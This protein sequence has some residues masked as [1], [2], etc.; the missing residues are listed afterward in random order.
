VELEFYLGPVNAVM[1]NA[2]KR[3]E[4]G[5]I[6]SDISIIEKADGFDPGEFDVAIVGVEEGI[7]SPGNEECSKAPDEIR[8]QLYELRAFNNGLRVAD[9][10]NIR[11]RT[12]NDKLIALTEVCSFLI[13]N[14]VIPVVIGGG[15]DFTLAI[16]GAAVTDGS[17]NLT[18]LDHTI[19][20]SEDDGDLTSGSFLSKLFSEKAKKPGHIS[21]IGVQKYFYSKFQED[22]IHN[23]FFDLIRLGEIK[24]EAIKNAEPYLRDTDILSVDV[25]SVKRTDMPAQKG[26]MPNGLFSHE[27]CQL[28]W[29][30][31]MSDRLKAFG[32]FEVNPAKDDPAGSGVALAAQ[33]IWHFI[34]GV[35]LR[36][37]D[38]PLRD[39]ETYSIYIVHLEDLGLDLRFFN[40]PQNGRWWAGIPREEGEIIVSCTKEDYDN[41]L[42][43]EISDRWIFFTKKK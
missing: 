24:G 25:S 15:H 1:L 38:Y 35:S 19:D 31:G 8:K 13:K 26:A 39:I 7:N 43:N 21:V 28:A 32:L 18:I 29:Y 34:E 12:A 17:F 2:A 9:M 5:R 3:I 20:I 16:T 10:G 37:K 22:F 11:G 36:H 40:N 14:S 23:N 27:I 41:A 4:E 33:T 6:G 42:K 30:A